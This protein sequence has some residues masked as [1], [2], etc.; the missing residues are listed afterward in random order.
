LQNGIYILNISNSSFNSSQKNSK[1]IKL[2]NYEKIILLIYAFLYCKT[3]GSQNATVALAETQLVL[4]D[5]QVI[6]L[7]RFT[8][9]PLGQTARSIKER[10]NRLKFCIRGKRFS[11]N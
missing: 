9:M 7:A 6:R 5:H 2:K 3:Y 11:R 10:N 4:V 8:P 1:T